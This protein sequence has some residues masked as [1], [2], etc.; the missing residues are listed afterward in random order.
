MNPIQRIL[1]KFQLIVLDGAMATELE[2]H[3]HDLN[4]SLWSAKILYE[5]PD[6]IKRVHRDYFEAGADCAITASYQA[7]VEGY[8][9][10]GLSED[11]ALKLIQSSVQ[12][13]VQAR[14]EFWADVT[15][16]ASQ[17]TRPKPL[18]AASVGPYGAFLADGSEY[19]GD[20]KLSEE[21]LMEFHRPRMKALIEAGADI[22]ACETIPCLVEAKAITRLLK[23]FPGTYAWISFSAKDEQHISNGE[24][25][26]ACAKWL[27]E[28]EQ[29]AAV[30]INCTLPKFIPS[31]IHEIHSHTDKPVV[32]YPNLGEEYDPVTKTWQGHTCTETFGQS[33]R[34]WYEAG[35]R[36]IGG[37]CR[38]Q[39]QD[40]RE[41]VAW[42]REV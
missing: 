38:T 29:V 17:Q 2:R 18:V 12:I 36:M 3:G 26:A 40:I 20:Y 35:A 22:L 11:E 32:V 16:T 41:I 39:P 6:S 28:H 27:N 31:L 13:A 34:Q 1:N 8:V 25:I 42:S 21:Q 4:D 30:G 19:R 37:C 5:H 24:S 33:A 23:E 15:A 9:Q 14:D 10:R 7:T